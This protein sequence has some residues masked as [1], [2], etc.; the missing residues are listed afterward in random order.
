MTA[1]R[2]P[3]LLGPA[4]ARFIAD[5]KAVGAAVA[6]FGSPIHVVFPQVFADNI[7]R[8][9]TVLGEQALAYRICYA[10]KANQAHAFAATARRCG[11]DIDVA[12][13]GELA[14]ALAAGFPADRIEA[15]GPKGDALLRTLV[16]IG[17]LINVDNLW[18]LERLDELA[19]DRPDAAATPVLLRLSGFDRPGPARPASRF[20]IDIGTAYQALTTLCRPG[21]RLELRGVAFH[22]DSG[23]V[24]ERVRA[25]SGCL[26]V[27]EQAYALGLR[28]RIVNIGGGFRQAFSADPQSFD[29]YAHALAAGLTGEG[30]ALGWPGHTFG[31]RGVNGTRAGVPAFH[32]YGGD[33][34]GV[35]FLDQVLA[36]DL[37]GLPLAATM[38]DAMLELWLEPGKALV[39]HAGVTVSTVEFTKQL[40]DGATLVNLD[41]ARDTI[42]PA[43]QEVMLDPVVIRRHPEAA[44]APGP[45]AVFLAGHLCLERDLVARHLVHLDRLPLPGDLVVFVNTAAYQMDLSASTALMHPTPPKVVAHETGTG[46]ELEADRTSGR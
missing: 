26:G 43:D 21:C 38:R 27:I 17:A 45:C 37:D 19:R 8:F 30:P 39:D 44:Y 29:A 13:I 15:T 14:S 23:D 1:L 10:H 6:R 16:G 28:P 33:A 24:G 9:R 2:L 31:Y 32:K 12:S 36:A 3:P 18:E 4:A 11:I 42:T 40:A 46:Y 25:V 5:E 22:L 7:E 34:P 35:H 20:G 41:I